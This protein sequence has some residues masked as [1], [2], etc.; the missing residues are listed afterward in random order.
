MSKV[1]GVGIIGCGNI[2]TAYLS[3]IPLFKNLQVVACADIN[4][5]AAKAQAEKFDVLAQSVDELLANPDVDVVV[6]LTIPAAHFEVSKRVLE[7]GKHVYSEKPFVLSL[8][9]GNALREL[10]DAKGLKVGS[11][12]D[13]FLG[14]AHQLARK[15]IDDGKFGKITSG[16]ARVLSPGMEDWHPNPDFFFK[17]GGGPILDM[18]PYYVTN[19]VNLLGPVARVTAMATTGQTERTIRNGPREGENV[20]VSTP[21]NIHSILEFESGACVAFSAS[22][23]S[24]ANHQE[25]ELYGTDGTIF[26]PDPNFFSGN[27]RIGGRKRA[28]SEPVDMWDHPFVPANYDGPF[29]RFP[30]Y[31]GAG[32]S[33][34]MASIDEGREARCSLPNALHVIDVLTSILKA[35]EL[36]KAVEIE[37]KCSQPAALGP[38]EA[39]AM[40]R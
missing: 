24:W 37:T 25:M 26:V 19:L 2:S 36:G 33:D 38:D 1:Y 11:A 14:G 27:M 4:L 28:E 30:N 18:G 39:R 12:P 8:E 17:P 6:N 13:T 31:R 20:P 23:E 32:L 3:L 7:A 29:V 35:A 10:A 5:D 34:M 40:M 15:L 16:M 21:T 22:W 9:E